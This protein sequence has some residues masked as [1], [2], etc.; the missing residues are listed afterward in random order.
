MFDDELRMLLDGGYV[1]GGRVGYLARHELR[2][3]ADGPIERVDHDAFVQLVVGRDVR[4]VIVRVETPGEPSPRVIV[5][6]RDDGAAPRVLVQTGDL[7]LGGRFRVAERVDDPALAEA[8]WKA[9][10]LP[11]CWDADPSQGCC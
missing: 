1:L 5:L 6:A 3:R 9:T 2:A 11:A 8:R 7:Y 10:P 4:E